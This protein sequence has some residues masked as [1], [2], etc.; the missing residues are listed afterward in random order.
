MNITAKTL[1]YFL[2]LG[3][4]GFSAFALRVC[5]EPTYSCMNDD[6]YEQ[7]LQIVNSGCERLI[8]M[9][10]CPLKFACA[11]NPEQL[12]EPPSPPQPKA[13]TPADA[14]VTLLVYKDTECTG[15]IMR[16][17]TFSTFTKP[18]SSCCTCIRRLEAIKR[19][20]QS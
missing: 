17:L 19:G 16:G 1:T 13:D 9:E 5:P 14:C 11:Y 15:P 4:L 7:C 2:L 12:V 10:S 6:N 18:G 3:G 20:A 8:T